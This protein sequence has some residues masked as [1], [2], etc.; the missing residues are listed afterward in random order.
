VALRRRYSTELRARWV[1]V[2]A[3][4]AEHDAAKFVDALAQYHDVATP[5]AGVVP[6]AVEFG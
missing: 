4:I 2:P 1:R 3:P 6:L 5:R